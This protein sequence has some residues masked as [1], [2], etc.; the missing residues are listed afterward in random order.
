PKK[1]YEERISRLQDQLVNNDLLFLQKV[2]SQD[3]SFAILKGKNN[4]LC[5]KRE[6]EFAE[7]GK[8]YKKFS[9]WAFE[10]KTGDKDELLFVPDFWAKVS[11][12]SDD[13]NINTCPFYKDCFYYRHYRGLYS[14]DVLIV[15]HHL[16]VYDLLSDFNLLPFHTQLIID[17][18]HKLEDVISH[19]FGNMLKRSRVVWLLYRLARLKIEVDHL[20]GPVDSFFKRIDI[21][22]QAIYPIPDSI[23]NGL[24]NLKG[25]LALN[26]VL[27]RLNTYKELTSNEKLKDR[28][29]TTTAYVK[30]LIRDIDDFIGQE[31]E[32]K[33]YYM[34]GNKGALELKSSLVE[35]KGPF[36]DLIRGYDNLIMT[37]A[38]LTAGGSF[39]FLKDRL[40][41]T[42]FEE[43]VIGSPFDYKRQAILYIDRELPRPDRENKETFQQESV[44]TIENLINASRGRALV[45]FTSYKHLNFVSKN[46]KVDHPLRSQGD[47]PLPRLI[48]WFKDT[49]NP[50][51]LATTTFWQGI[52]IKGEKLSL[53]IITKMPFGSPG[54]PVYDER[55]RRL[56]NRWFINLALPSAILLLKQGFGRL[57]RGVDD[58]GVVA[59]LDTRLVASSYGK[60]I[61][62]SLPDMDIVHSIEEVKGFFDSIPQ[63]VSSRLIREKT[64]RY[65]S[66]N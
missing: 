42:D 56:K 1:R 47:M 21:L 4:Y 48:Q 31:N 7:F 50:V 57:I 19:V 60:T 61:V 12:D 59:M 51:L 65:S 26:S 32:D 38:T 14:K 17:E 2:L 62:S 34:I 9:K 20:L 29:K 58:Y 52:D 53:V 10:T 25:A 13:C 41:I 63:P 54:D 11:G 49:P 45:L 15:N 40:G 55:C 44:K 22:S 30:V 8:S 36:N 5:L 43:M 35:S 37:S 27:S 18:A 3:F 6:R 64:E 24:I 16:L 28:I 46:I 66:Y 33:V 23:I 39:G